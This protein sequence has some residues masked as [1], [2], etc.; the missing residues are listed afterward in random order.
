MLE[1]RRGK[2]GIGDDYLGAFHF[3]ANKEISISVC[4]TQYNNDKNRSIGQCLR[5]LL[6]FLP[7]EGLR[8]LHTSFPY[9]IKL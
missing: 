3:L 1:I 9:C 8:A 4:H 5:A 7:L 2:S 6:L